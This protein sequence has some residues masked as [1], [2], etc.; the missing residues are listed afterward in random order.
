MSGDV[1]FKASKGALKTIANSGELQG[2]CL[3]GADS[4]AAQARGRSG[5]TYVTDVRPGKFRC[6]ARASTVRGNPASFFREAAT[7]ALRASRPRI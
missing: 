2:V 1:R 4:S 6:H 5:G 7:H 3:R